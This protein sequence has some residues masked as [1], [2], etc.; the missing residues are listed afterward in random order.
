[1]S[2]VSDI[3]SALERYAPNAY[4][5]SWD[6]CGLLLGRTEA[7]VSAVLV[8]L[9]VTGEVID[10]AA[11]LGAR[12]IVSHHPVFFSADRITDESAQGRVILKLAENGIAACCMH[13]NLD[14]AERG[15]NYSL[16]KALEIPE[17]YEPFAVITAGREGRDVG[18]GLIFELPEPVEASDFAARVKKALGCGAV[19]YLASGPVRRV[20]VCSGSGGSV[21][22][23]ALKAGCDTFFTGECKHS[24]FLEAQELGVSLIAAGHFNTENVICAPVMEYLARTLPDVEVHRSKACKEPYI[25]L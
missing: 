24:L 10:E 2:R 13:T 1:M 11:G 22:H 5:K 7:E 14:A 15:V 19:Q 12:M 21:F 23:E 18:E 3:V 9:D 4:A 8:S 25:C 17:P 20:G 16:L 6:N